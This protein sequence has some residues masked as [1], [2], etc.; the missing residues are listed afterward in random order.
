VRGVILDIVLVHAAFE[1]LAQVLTQYL[2]L[3]WCKRVYA[4]PVSDVCIQS[5]PLIRESDIREN[6][7]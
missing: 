6:R 5:T 2:E 3:R 4:G 1:R 7:L